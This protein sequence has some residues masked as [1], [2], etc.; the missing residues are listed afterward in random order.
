MFYPKL[1]IHFQILQKKR[2]SQAIKVKV[3]TKIYYIVNRKQKKILK[4][5][6]KKTPKKLK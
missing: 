6:M 5:L 4:I 3:T 2:D 1:L